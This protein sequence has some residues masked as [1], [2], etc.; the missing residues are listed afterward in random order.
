[1]GAMIRK[2]IAQQFR[3][4]SGLLGHYAANFMKKNN[5]DY[6]AHVCD[7]LNLQNSDTVLEIGCGAGYAIRL[8]TEKNTRCTVDALDFSPMM[9]KKAE[10]NNLKQ[11]SA[12]RVHFF[13]GDFGDYDFGDIVYS[14]IFAINV[15]YFWNDLSS[16]FSKIYSLLKTG[17]R[18]ILF[19]SS[20]ERLQKVPFAV[21]GVFNKYTVTQVENDLSSAGFMKL[22]HERVV[23][24][25]SDTF[26][27]CA[28]K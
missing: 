14:K 2:L 13:K 10:K 8:I 22:N 5:Q 21:D 3:R 18:L 15:I 12:G 27:V 28:D 16:K 17:G 23:K 26:Y 11:A 6:Y 19:M 4:P 20:P 9:L 25:E 7:R 24:N 1:M